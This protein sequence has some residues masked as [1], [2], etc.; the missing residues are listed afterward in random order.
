MLRSSSNAASASLFGNARLPT[1][2]WREYHE[3]TKHSV[4]SLRRTPHALD[5]A[6]M[7]DPF[8]HYEGVP[9][10][11][12]PADPPI[13]EIPALEVL[14]GVAGA[15]PAGDGPTFLSQLLFHSAA[16]SASKRVPSTGY[17][18]AL[19]V[20]PSS[21]NLHPTEFHFL[22][23]GLKE[24]PDGLYHYRPSAHM[25]EQRAMGG[26]QMKLAGSPAPIVFVLTSIAWREAWKYR[27]RAYRYCLHDMGHAWQ[28]L[29]LAARAIGC[30]SFAVGHFPDDDVARFC[31]LHEDE[32]PMLVVELR[33]TSIP[34][35]E[36]DASA[37]VWYGG[38]AHR[39]SR[40]TIA[41]PRIDGIHGVTKLGKGASRGISAAG[42][43]PTGSGEIKLPPPASSRPRFGRGA[44]M[45]RSARDF[46]GGTQSMSLPQLS[47][48]LAVATRPLFADFAA[49][50]FIQLYLYVHRVDGLQPGVYRL[51]PERAEL[52]QVK[53]GDQRV[54]AA[55]LS[56]G[57]D[58][59]GNRSEERR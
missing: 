35:R 22:T 33:G 38:R 58:L 31:R 4:E 39:L 13:P 56:L 50:R 37:A 47:A 53:S 25:A 55:G 7:P 23:T 42:P 12:L 10:L 6:N 45:R 48:I 43:P 20:N 24:W 17:R 14:H 30:D 57:Q 36:P 52:E 8:R 34:V 26:L 1:M 18:Y 28:A 2:T 3:S 59:A 16:I 29:A 15:T 27:D 9:L 49:A 46:L 32:W 5:W 11:D 41:Y 19:R 51:W 40:E 44:R 54:A 21:G